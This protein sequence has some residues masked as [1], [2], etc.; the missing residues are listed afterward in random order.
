MVVGEREDALIISKMAVVVAPIEVVATCLTNK[1]SDVY[2]PV[3]HV[4]AMPHP[5]S[6]NV[7]IVYRFVSICFIFDIFVALYTKM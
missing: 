6:N 2:P 3:S 7:A 5:L 4:C 1:A